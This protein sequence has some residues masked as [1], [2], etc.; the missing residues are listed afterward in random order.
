MFHLAFPPSTFSVV[1]VI[2]RYTPTLFACPLVHLATC[3]IWR[4]FHSRHSGNESLA[5][6]RHSHHAKSRHR[7]HHLRPSALDPSRSDSDF[8]LRSFSRVAPSEV[9]LCSIPGN[10]G[11]L[12]AGEWNKLLAAVEERLF[13]TRAA[14]SAPP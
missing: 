3:H 10:V 4:Y 13:A 8:C 2:L 5:L 9:T 7:Y 14:R 1:I 6:A 12:S 11:R